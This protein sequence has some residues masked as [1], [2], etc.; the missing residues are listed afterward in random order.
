VESGGI[1]YLVLT[2]SKALNIITDLG[3]SVLPIPILWNVQMNKRMKASIVVIMGLGVLY[4]F[5]TH[6]DFLKV[7]ADN[8][9]HS[10]A[11]AST[12][13][14][15]Y[16]RS[17]GLSGDFLFDSTGLT[18]WS[19]TELNTGIIACSIPCL[20]PLFQFMLENTLYGSNGKMNGKTSTT[21]YA[22]QSTGQN[23]ETGVNSNLERAG[24]SGG[25]GGIKLDT[26][27]RQVELKN[28]GRF[29][30]D[31]SDETLLALEGPG[32]RKTTRISVSRETVESS[33]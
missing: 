16:I 24:Y 3:F 26:L 2:S 6:P 17:Y 9:V 15:T 32:I 11:I 21:T 4:V 8:S 28:E 20:K 31:V 25:D 10:A 13:K 23:I 33:S 18:I 19:A 22:M 1:S 14:L 30:D 27:E 7:D 12:V 29:P 5:Q